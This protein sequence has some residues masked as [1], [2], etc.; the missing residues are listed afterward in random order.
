MTDRQEEKKRAKLLADRPA[1][2]EKQAAQI[3]AASTR[4]SDKRNDTSRPFA[5][6]TKVGFL[7]P[8]RV[9]VASPHADDVGWSAQMAD[10]LGTADGRVVD[11]IQSAASRVTTVKTVNSQGEADR[12]GVETEQVLAFIAENAPSNPVEASLLMQMAAV[13]QVSMAMLAGAL[14]TDRRDAQG[15]Y[16]R[17]MNQTMRTFTAQAEALQ[18]LRTG[19]KQQVEVRYVYV[20]ARTQTVVNGG[21]GGGVPLENHQQPHGP[22]TGGLPFAPGAPVWSK[23][24]GGDAVPVAGHQG[25]EAMPDARWSQ[26]GGSE[27]R[28]QRKLRLR[29]LD[30][31]DDQGA[32]NGAGVGEALSEDAA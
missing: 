12:H 17:L 19:G 16:V 21:Q 14:Q 15:D 23:D 24:A 11:M 13:Q 2:T 18:K 28:D 25:T 20:D 1:P 7:G 22:G 3:T 8:N 26:S 29:A 4:V 6:R 30:G 32:G 10:A 5:P 31:R 27:G 9:L